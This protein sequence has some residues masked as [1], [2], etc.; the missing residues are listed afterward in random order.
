MREQVTDT[1]CHPYL[2]ED[3][4]MV[5]LRTRRL[6]AFKEATRMSLEALSLGFTFTAQGIL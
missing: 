3:G 1:K 5:R 6:I 2:D 4:N